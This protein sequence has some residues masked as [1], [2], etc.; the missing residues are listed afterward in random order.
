MPLTVAVKLICHLLVVVAA[1]A[2]GR[3]SSEKRQMYQSIAA[4]TSPRRPLSVSSSRS[5]NLRQKLCH[6]HRRQVIRWDS[7]VAGRG[8]GRTGHLF[9]GGK[10]E[11]VHREL[12]LPRPLWLM[13]TRRLR[14]YI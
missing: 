9:L 1:A 6:V 12:P 7:V 10:S 2:V 4:L 8:N 3:E 11:A 5:H 13:E 14:V